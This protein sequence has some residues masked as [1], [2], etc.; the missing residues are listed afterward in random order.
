MTIRLGW[1]ALLGLILGPQAKAIV[2]SGSNPNDPIWASTFN[3]VGFASIAGVGSC[4]GSLLS[5]G[6]HVLTAAHCVTG[7]SGGTV[8]FTTSGGTFTYTIASMVGNPSFDINNLENGF[9]LGIITLTQIA[10]ASISR[11]G[12]FTGSNELGQTGTV[13]GYGREG[14]G[15]TG[16]SGGTSGTGR[17]GVNSIDQILNARVLLYDFDQAGVASTNAISGSGLALIG[18][19]STFRGDSGGP[20]FLSGLIAGVHSFNSCF[21][22]DQNLLCDSGP[23]LDTSINATFGEVFGDT[24]VSAN[25]AWINGVTADVPE[26]V[27][28]AMALAGLAVVAAARFRR[29]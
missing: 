2:V 27:T 14:T 16:G 20:T 22:A 10:D 7:G 11:Y 12:L 25:L 29:R 8:A 3:G 17:Q 13:V 6:L 4:S 23:D 24:R 5:S 18:E 28:S 15:L 19:V 1:I 9:D 21:D 26:P